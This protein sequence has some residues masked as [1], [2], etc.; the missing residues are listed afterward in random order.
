VLADGRYDAYIR[1]VDLGRNQMVV[2]LIQ[3]F[4]GQAAA[5]AFIAD[6]KPRDAAQTVEGYIRNQNPRLRTL[7]LAPDLRV[8]VVRGHDTEN[9]CDGP[10]F[11]HNLKMLISDVSYHTATLYFTLTVAGGAVHHIKEISIQPAC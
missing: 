8:D 7:P 2:D 4:H 3:V 11:L 5:E 9:G 1:T 10:V 6:G